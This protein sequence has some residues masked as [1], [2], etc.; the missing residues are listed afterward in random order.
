MIVFVIVLII[1]ILGLIFV[2]DVFLNLLVELVINIPI[3]LFIY[4]RA[5]IDVMDRKREVEYFIAVILA[6]AI[7]LLL[8]QFIT[9]IPL[10]WPLTIWIVLTF[11]LARIMVKQKVR[12]QL[13]HTKKKQH[14]SRRARKPGTLKRI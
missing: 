13:M 5:K 3:L 4:Y 7:T 2:T 8:Y 14:V 6:G 11:I 10:I 1:V 9:Q 12:Q